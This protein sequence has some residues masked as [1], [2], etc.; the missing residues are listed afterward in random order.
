MKK[1][2]MIIAAACAMAAVPAL[3]ESP[4]TSGP[5][6]YEGGGMRGEHGSYM[7]GERGEG[8]RSERGE[9]REGGFHRHH[10]M[11]MVE[12]CKYIT[13]RQRRGDELITKRF[14][15]CGGERD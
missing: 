3:A 15:R 4:Q 12:G 10:W 7:R 5:S 6:Q 14:K 11:G 9:A 13:V 1:L 8:M 2:P